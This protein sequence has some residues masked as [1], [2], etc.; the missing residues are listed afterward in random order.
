MT[1][2]QLQTKLQNTYLTVAMNK[3]YK[4]KTAPSELRAELKQSYGDSWKD[5]PLIDIMF[6]TKEQSLID[7]KVKER[8]KREIFLSMSEEMANSD[9]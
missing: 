8:K 9:V 1:K 2:K 5:K 6:D 3:S 4:P 7:K